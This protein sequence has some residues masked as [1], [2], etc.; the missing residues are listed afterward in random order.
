MNEQPFDV[1]LYGQLMLAVAFLH[2]IFFPP[3]DTI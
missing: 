1:V 3:D 2:Y